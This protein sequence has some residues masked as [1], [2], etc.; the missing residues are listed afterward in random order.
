MEPKALQSL[1]QERMPDADIE[2]TGDGYQ[3]EIRV[4]SDEFEG[5]LPVKRQQKVYSVI[6]EEIQSGQVHAVRIKALTPAEWKSRH[7][8]D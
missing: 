4:L 6:N 1:L 5:L 2:V 7:S 8:K 3:Y